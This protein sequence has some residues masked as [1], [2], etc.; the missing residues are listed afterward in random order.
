M[1]GI[2]SGS[3]RKRFYSWDKNKDVHEN[4]IDNGIS[5]RAM[6]SYKHNHKLK[7]VRYVERRRK[8]FTK[9]RA[10]DIL[11]RNGFNYV[12]IAKLFKIN[13]SAVYVHKENAIKNRVF[14]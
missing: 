11:Y 2:G 10:I 5:Y 1:G 7:C 12:D 8:T 13:P 9:Q 6:C 14:R 4:A 3:P